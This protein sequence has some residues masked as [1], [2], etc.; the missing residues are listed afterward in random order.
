M[1]LMSKWDTLFK[2]SIWGV[3]KRAVEHVSRKL[4]VFG[5]EDISVLRS[6]LLLIT[7]EEI[8]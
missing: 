7:F 4:I 1:I 8:N 6:H 5:G 3:S 2:G